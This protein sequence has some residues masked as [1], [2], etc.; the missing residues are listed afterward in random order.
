MKGWIPV[1]DE[2]PPV[3]KRVKLACVIFIDWN[4][5]DMLWETKGWLTESGAWSM[6][7]VRGLKL[8]YKPTHWMDIDGI[9]KCTSKGCNEPSVGDYNGCGDHACEY[10]MRK[11]N[12]EFDEEYK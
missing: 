12:D 6:K 11:W 10:H 2:L 3:R 5:E 4:L 1:D 8:E 9:I 7:M